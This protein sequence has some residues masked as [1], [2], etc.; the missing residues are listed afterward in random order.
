ML[1]NLKLWTHS[2]RRPIFKKMKE[3]LEEKFASIDKGLE[4][5]YI[6]LHINTSDEKLII[7]SHLRSKSSVTLK[8]SR[9]FRGA[10]ELFEDRIEAE[11]LFDGKY[12][13]CSIPLPAVW[14]LTSATGQ[15]SVWP[16]SAPQDVLV[17]LLNPQLYAKAKERQ[18]V[19]INNSKPQ[20]T[21][22]LP[23][24]GHLRRVK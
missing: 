14:G 24:K 6:L 19:E 8:I 1:Q 4:G 12:F 10:M 13:N 11:L 9:W 17:S 22:P 16:D 21:V 15:H 3:S 5:E 20:K 18:K 7:P 23:A 2:T